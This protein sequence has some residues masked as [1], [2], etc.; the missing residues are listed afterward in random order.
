MSR[1]FKVDI[2]PTIMFCPKCYV[3]IN[4]DFCEKI[5]QMHT[6]ALFHIW[7]HFNHKWLNKKCTRCIN[8]LWCHIATSDHKWNKWKGWVSSYYVTI[9]LSIEICAGDRK[10]KETE[11]T[12]TDMLYFENPAKCFGFKQKISELLLSIT[13]EVC[14]QYALRSTSEITPKPQNP[15]QEHI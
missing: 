7:W 9:T 2:D 1:S 4:I 11:K 15:T 5:M 6:E 3:H 8:P 10:R 14:M 13:I 12:L